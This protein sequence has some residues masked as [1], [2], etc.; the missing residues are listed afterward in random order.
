MRKEAT[1][2]LPFVQDRSELR[3]V[4]IGALRGL[5]IV[6]PVYGVNR[7]VQGLTGTFELAP[8]MIYFSCMIAYAAGLVFVN[9]LLMLREHQLK[10]LQRMVE[11]H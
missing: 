1:M 3:A 11:G 8:Q 5:V 9:S 6:L 4:I 2:R 7:V 10:V